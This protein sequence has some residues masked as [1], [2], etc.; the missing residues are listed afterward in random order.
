MAIA[1]DGNVTHSWRL[2]PLARSAAALAPAMKELLDQV[3]QSGQ[4]IDYVAVADGPG[5]FTGLRIGVTSAKALAYALGCPVVAVDSLACLAAI[6]WSQRPGA[7]HVAV[8][9]NAYRGQVFVADWTHQQWQ[10]ALRSGDFS[11]QSHVADID[12]WLVSLG[13]LPADAIVAVEPCLVNKQYN[14]DVMAVGPS[15]DW[16]ARLAHVRAEHGHFTSP[17]NLLPRYLRDS[18]AEEKLR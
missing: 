5:S 16:V 3:R 8:A 4:S 17:M 11:S 18:A 6:P 9:L 15:A 7:S 10:Q 1:S 14:R 12:S 13:P 2:D